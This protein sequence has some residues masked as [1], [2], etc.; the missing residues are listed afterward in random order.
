[1]AITD[2]PRIMT[3]RLDFDDSYTME[4]YLATGGYTALHKA[5]T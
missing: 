2:A 3:A 5:L 1:M 4:R